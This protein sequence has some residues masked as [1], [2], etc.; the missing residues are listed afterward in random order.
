MTGLE[1]SRQ[2]PKAAVT[3]YKPAVF[4]DEQSSIGVAIECNPEVRGTLYY[5]SLERL[6]MKGAASEV[7][8]AA[9]RPVVDCV[10][11]C[12]QA[13]KNLGRKVESGAIR[14]VEHKMYS[15]K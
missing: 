1:I 4:I 9:I 7:D 10:D 6:R 5:F 15:A 12:S 11:S 8:V 3:I 14:T 13:F 2:D